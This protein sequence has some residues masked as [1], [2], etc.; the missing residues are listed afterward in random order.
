M[1]CQLI[2]RNAGSINNVSK[3]QLRGAGMKCLLLTG[4]FDSVSQEYRFGVHRAI[5]A[6]P[7]RELKWLAFV[8]GSG[9]IKRLDGDVGG[10]SAGECAKVYGQSAGC[11]FVR[12]RQRG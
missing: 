12:R 4:D 3:R 11:S 6:H 2:S 10:F 7:R 5:G 1:K 8:H 9:E